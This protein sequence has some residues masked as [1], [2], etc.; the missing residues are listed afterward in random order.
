MVA[1]IPV[2]VHAVTEYLNLKPNQTL[3]DC[4]LGFGGHSSHLSSLTSHLKIIGIDQDN[5][6]IQGQQG[7]QVKKGNFKNLKELVKEKVDGILFDLGVSSYQIDTAERGFSFRF[8]GP[9]DMRMGQDIRESGEREIR[10]QDI[11]EQSSEDELYRIFK[12]Y[13]E[14]RYSKRIARRVKDKLPRTTFGLKEIVERAIPGWRKRESVSRIF[15]ALR[16]VVNNELENLKIALPQAV[17]LLNPG[18]RIVV[19]SYHSL[20]DRIVKH[21]FRECQKNAILKLL[22]KKPVLAG[23]DEIKDNPRSKSAKLRAAEKV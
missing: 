2:L 11:I 14:E 1:H 8:D 13:G 16:I 7:I 10:A 12:E 5:D 21:F 4:T 23:A 15:Q 17:E 6:A 18:G 20:E 19:I 3:I 9:L 22:T